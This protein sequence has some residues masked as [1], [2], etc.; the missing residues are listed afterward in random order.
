MA[1]ALQYDQ[2]ATYAPMTLYLPNLTEQEFLEWSERFA[3]FQLEYSADGELIIMPGTSMETGDRNNEITKQLTIWADLDGRGRAYDS[4]TSFLLPDGA[5]RSPD[6]AWVSSARRSAAKR[7][8][9][10][11]PVLAPDFVIE[12]KSPSDRLR[13][14]TAKMEDWIANGVSLGWLLDPD[15]RTA[16]I[17]RPGRDP[18]TILQPRRLNGESPVQGFLL[19][20]DP[21]WAIE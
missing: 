5:R 20:L 15:L 14:L 17:Y 8:G 16:T 2:V 10:T 21:I 18:E 9:V 6:A 19:N 13:K 11:F 12:L 7:P 3:D 1:L 4:S